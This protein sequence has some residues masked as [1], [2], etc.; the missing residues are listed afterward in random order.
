M[1][2][3]SFF[4]KPLPLAGVVIVLLFHCGKEVKMSKFSDSGRFAPC[5]QSPNCVSTQ[6]PANDKQ[7]S[8]APIAFRGEP[9]KVKEK[10]LTTL[11]T[12]PRVEIIQQNDRYIHAVFTTLIMR[13]KDDVEFYINES[14]NIIEFRSA[15]R[16]GY[17]DLGKNRSRM[18]K[19]RKELEKILP[20]Q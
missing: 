2:F 17:S 14:S 9:T 7:H 1:S 19:F 5:P 6:A 8:I 18:E 13:F 16:V 11:Q 4:A 20:G 15:S 12:F 10:I 3:S